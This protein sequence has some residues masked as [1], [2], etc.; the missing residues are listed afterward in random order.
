MDHRQKRGEESTPLTGD[1]KTTFPAASQ[2]EQHRC[3]PRTSTLTRTQGHMPVPTAA[4]A[5]ECTNSTLSAHV[6]GALD[7]GHLLTKK[8]PN[9]EALLVGAGIQPNGF[10]LCAAFD[11]DLIPSGIIIE[12]AHI[13]TQQELEVDDQTKSDLLDKL[14]LLLSPHR[15]LI[16]TPSNQYYSTPFLH[17]K[18][19]AY[20]HLIEFHNSQ[21]LKH[22]DYS[23]LALT[24]LIDQ[25]EGGA[26]ATGSSSVE[27]SRDADR[28]GGNGSQ[29]EEEDSIGHEETGPPDDSS[30]ERGGGQGEDNDDDNKEE[31]SN[32]KQ[33]RKVHFKVV[34]EV[35]DIQTIRV[36]GSLSSNV[37]F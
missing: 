33:D 37:R 1:E 13:L 19:C 17:E 14:G 8:G 18:P 34:F 15:A 31:G 5:P 4:K 6:F 11:R 16:F 22:D 7:V 35:Q 29:R 9:I 20:E 23:H 27:F 21:R 12:E 25:D 30:L 36:E 10:V 3:M 26:N 24:P 32:A 28:P 2:Y